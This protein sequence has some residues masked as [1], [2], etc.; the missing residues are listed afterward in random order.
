MRSCQIDRSDTLPALSQD[1]DRAVD[2]TVQAMGR[3]RRLLFITARGCLSIPDFPPIGAATAFIAPSRN[4]SWTLHRAGPFRT[5]AP[6]PARDHLALS[7]G[8]GETD[9]HAAP[10]RGHR[11]IAEMDGYFDAVWVLTQNVDG[12]H[13]RA[14]LQERARRARQLA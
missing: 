10:N 8:A 7:P 6:D 9:P 5:H 12:L 2:R 4:P 14:G 3:A 11:V 13:Q 1:D